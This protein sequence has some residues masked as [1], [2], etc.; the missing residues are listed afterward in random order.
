M[1]S[2]KVTKSEWVQVAFLILVLVVMIHFVDG[3]W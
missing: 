3:G 1:K 2:K